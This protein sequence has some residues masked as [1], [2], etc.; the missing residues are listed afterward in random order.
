MTR[1]VYAGASER[2]HLKVGAAGITLVHERVSWPV[3]GWR[4]TSRRTI[5][6]LAELVAACPTPRM[7]LPLTAAWIDVVRLRGARQRR[8]S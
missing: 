1:T 4:E 2:C 3:A 7:R 6:S 5:R 8:A